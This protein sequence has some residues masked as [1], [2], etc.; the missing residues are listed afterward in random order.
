MTEAGPGTHGKD[1][2]ER[3]CRILFVW[4]SRSDAPSPGNALRRALRWRPVT[5]K[6]AWL[7]APV[8]G[9]CALAGWSTSLMWTGYYADWGFALA[10]AA[11]AT[12]VQGLVGSYKIRR[13][14]CAM[15]LPSGGPDSEG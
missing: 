4:N 9:L 15:P 7:F 3:N 11:F 5:S 13:R 6:Q 2:T 12:A 10:F 8:V 14:V 1:A